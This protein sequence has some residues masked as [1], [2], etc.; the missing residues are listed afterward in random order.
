M[1]KID[2]G[3]RVT[4]YII[5]T[6]IIIIMWLPLV[7][8]NNDSQFIF[9]SYYGIRFLYYFIMEGI[10]KYTFGKLITKTKVVKKNGG[11][12]NILHIL[13]RSSLRLLPLDI[14]SYIFGTERG[15]HD[16]LSSTRL[17][18]KY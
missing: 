10:L 3:I 4:N 17:K 11:K 2:K 14:V 9:F 18:F 15:M 8:K 13:I 5:D 16:I 1:K 7:Y 12:A 6:I